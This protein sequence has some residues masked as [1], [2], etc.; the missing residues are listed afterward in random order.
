MSWRARSRR[1][2]NLSH[3]LKRG[4]Y[5]HSHYN[6][7]FLVD[8]LRSLG[9]NLLKADNGLDA[10]ALTCQHQPDLILLD[11]IMPKMDGWEVTKRIRQEDTIKD[12]P[13]IIMSASTLAATET[14]SR[15]VGANAFMAK[16]LRF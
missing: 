16:P 3:P 14:S 4:G 11:L 8:L 13:I 7:S 1:G 15:E 9:F 12:V 5:S 10:I 6:R 2:A